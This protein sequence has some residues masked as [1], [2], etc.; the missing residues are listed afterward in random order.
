MHKIISFRRPEKHSSLG[1]VGLPYTQV[2]FFIW[3]KSETIWYLLKQS[4]TLPWGNYL[5][6]LGLSQAMSV[7][8]PLFGVFSLYIIWLGLDASNPV[9]RVCDKASFKPVS[10]ATETRKKIESSLEASLDIALSNKWIRKALIRLRGCAGWSAPLLFTN[11]RRQV[12]SHWGQ[13]Y[14]PL[15]INTLL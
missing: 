11:H 10:S 13:H 8:H 2:F 9:F 1:G 14:M 5:E 4:D 15:L 12:F 6:M 7:I 3:P